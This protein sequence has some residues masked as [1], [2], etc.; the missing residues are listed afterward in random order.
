MLSNN[1]RVI[2]V[3]VTN[4]LIRRVSEHKNSVYD[5]FTKRYHVHKLAYYEETTDVYSAIEREKQI[6]S[7]S[8]KK[9]DLLITN[10][11]KDLVDLFSELVQ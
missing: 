4:N 10:S 11:N 2:Y 9:K 1:N 3:G 8:R 6:K 7:W 5:S